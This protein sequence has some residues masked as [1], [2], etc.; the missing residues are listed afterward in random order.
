MRAILVTPTHA[1]EVGD[2]P[3]PPFGSRDLRIAVH[4]TEGIRA[5]VEEKQ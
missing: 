5:A 1:L 4:A 3:L 2:A